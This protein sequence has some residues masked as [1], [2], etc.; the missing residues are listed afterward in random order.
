[1]VDALSVHQSAM[2]LRKV[3][4]RRLPMINA[5]FPNLLQSNALRSLTVAEIMTPDLLAFD[6][7]MPIQKAAALLRFNELDAAPVIDEHG[8]LAGVLTAA[9]CAAWDD[10]TR[11]SAPFGL[12][13]QLPDFAPVS[14]IMSP[15]VESISE[16]APAIVA[17]Q[18]LVRRR[19]PRIYVVDSDHE[20]V[21]VVSM[22]DLVRHY[23][24]HASDRSTTDARAQCALATR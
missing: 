10:F 22:A 1:M 11:R 14:D 7:R 19:L 5:T 16:D 20:V 23:V 24:N 17:E 12:A 9:S 21:G 6:K 4:E 15:R 13:Q 18:R 3:K 8:C 2:S